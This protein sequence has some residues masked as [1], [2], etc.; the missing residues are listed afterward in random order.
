MFLKRYWKSATV[1]F[2]FCLHWQTEPISTADIDGDIRSGK[3]NSRRTRPDRLEADHG[4]ADK[5]Q[6]TGHREATLVCLALEN[7]NVSQ[8]SEI[9]MQSRGIEAPNSGST[10]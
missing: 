2:G 1:A 3:W 9:R 10:G 7:R 5:F 6:R 8:D 4:S